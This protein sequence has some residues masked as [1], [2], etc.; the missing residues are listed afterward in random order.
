MRLVGPYLFIVVGIFIGIATT[1]LF[2]KNPLSLV[3]NIVLGIV[4]SFFGLF[5]R[6]IMD[7][8]LGGK[9]SGALLA[10]ALGALLVTVVGNI[11][12]AAMFA[13]DR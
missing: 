7:V 11:V 5:V 4:G 12:Y 3:P 1:Y 9:I 2:S 10:A 13:K 6:D 8:T